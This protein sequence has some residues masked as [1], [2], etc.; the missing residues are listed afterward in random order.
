MTWQP[1]P[2]RTL[3]EAHPSHR[4]CPGPQRFEPLG[5]FCFSKWHILLLFFSSIRNLV[6]LGLC[7]VHQHRQTSCFLLGFT[8]PSR[9]SFLV[10]LLNSGKKKESIYKIKRNNTLPSPTEEIPLKSLLC[11][12]LVE[13]TGAVLIIP[14]LCHFIT[15]VCISFACF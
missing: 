10:S 3:G 1:C 4:P 9:I 15:Y 12:S 5:L 6:C 7:V 14:L 8:S 11:S 13:G 2:S